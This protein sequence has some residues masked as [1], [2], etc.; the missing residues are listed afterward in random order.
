VKEKDVCDNRT[1]THT[2]PEF[3]TSI[4][5]FNEH[6]RFPCTLKS[7]YFCGFDFKLKKTNNYNVILSFALY[8]YYFILSVPMI[9][10]HKFHFTH[11]LVTYVFLELPS[12]TL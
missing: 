3:V 12:R 5:K 1:L 6:L 7:L 2:H 8:K 10:M 4:S 9:S 11:D